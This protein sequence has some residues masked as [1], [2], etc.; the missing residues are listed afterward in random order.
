MDMG[1]F[2]RVIRT[3]DRGD[4]LPLEKSTTKVTGKGQVYFVNKFLKNKKATIPVATF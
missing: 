1:L 4:D 2:E 3:I